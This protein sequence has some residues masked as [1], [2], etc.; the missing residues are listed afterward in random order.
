MSLSE[1]LAAP[2][3]ALSS[4]AAGAPARV[5]SLEAPLAHS[6]PVDAIGNRA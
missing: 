1:P 6:Y 2:P 3:E 4:V 5:L